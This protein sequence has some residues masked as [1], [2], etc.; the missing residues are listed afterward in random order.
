MYRLPAI[1]IYLSL[2]LSLLVILVQSIGCSYVNKNVRPWPAIIYQPPG[3]SQSTGQWYLQLILDE[4]RSL[5][6]KNRYVNR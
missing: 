1:S 5:N 4:K 6:K 2:S 3:Q